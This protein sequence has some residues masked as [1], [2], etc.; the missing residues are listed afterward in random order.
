M[1]EVCLGQSYIQFAKVIF[2]QTIGIPMGLPCS[3]LI[4]DL[5]LSALEYKFLSVKRN[6]LSNSNCYIT[7]YMDDLLIINFEDFYLLANDIYPAE[8]PLEFSSWENNKIPYLDLLIERTEGGIHTSVYD[9]TRN[10]NFK[11][12]KYTHIDSNV[13]LNISRGIG[14][15]QFIRAGRICT[16]KETFRQEI[17][18]IVQA[19]IIN[20]FSNEFISD[21]WF[22]FCERHKDMVI[23]FG[24]T[25]KWKSV[26][27]ILRIFAKVNKDL[28]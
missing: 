18:N 21:I 2:K 22:K 12:R 6:P 28:S 14:N 26:S 16:T 9:K 5:T 1:L 8:L 11:V 23:R 27:W 25:N 10:F 13:H 24:L 17:T 3:P 19:F 15:S 20:N 7:R 4:A